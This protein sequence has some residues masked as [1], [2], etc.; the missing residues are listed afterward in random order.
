[1]KI[2]IDFDGVLCNTQRT[3]IRYGKKYYGHEPE[4]EGVENFHMDNGWTQE[5][6]WG[7]FYENIPILN[8]NLDIPKLVFEKAKPVSYALHGMIQ[9][10]KAGFESNIITA[11]NEETNYSGVEKDTINWLNKYEI[12]QY[13]NLVFDGNK[14]PYVEKFDLNYFVDDKPKNVMLL[15]KETNLKKVFYFAQPWNDF[16]KI[17]SDEMGDNVVVVYNWLHL[18][19]QLSLG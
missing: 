1:M 8:I 15:S 19:N 17:N 14:I 9:L 18:L 12:I 3:A 7:M 11:R 13:K 2:G 16:G 10:K 6:I 5:Q 4:K